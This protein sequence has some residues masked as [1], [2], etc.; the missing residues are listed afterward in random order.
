MPLVKKQGAI[1]AIYADS[2]VKDPAA[3]VSATDAPSK[4]PARAAL[5]SKSN[6]ATGT[7]K[8]LADKLIPGKAAPEGLGSKIALTPVCDAEN[9]PTRAKSTGHYKPSLRTSRPVPNSTISAST[10]PGAAKPVRQVGSSARIAIFE[11]PAPTDLEPAVARSSVSAARDRSLPPTRQGRATAAPSASG[12]TPPH[13]NASVLDSPAS[14]TRSKVRLAA[15][16]TDTNASPTVKRTLSMRTSHSVDVYQDEPM[17][18]R[19]SPR[20]KTR[21]AG[22]PPLSEQSPGTKTDGTPKRGS[23]GKKGRWV[24]GDM[25]LVDVSEAYAATGEAPEGFAEQAQVGTC[26]WLETKADLGQ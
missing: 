6:T 3:S 9:D 2:P 4:R 12:T 22:R 16:Q 13:A 7:R 11:D 19:Q 5:G 26:H 20:T 17:P 18:T 15:V 10:K 24:R 23:P 14:R 25:P 8:V 1:F 21:P